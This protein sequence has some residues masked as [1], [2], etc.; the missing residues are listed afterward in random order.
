MASLK[1]IIISFVILGIV[2]YGIEY[3]FPAIRGQ[4]I[5]RKGFAVDVVYWLFTPLVT[6]AL[7]RA[8][9]IGGVALIALLL[10]HK[11]GPELAD[12]FGPVTQQPWWLIAMEMLVLGD[13]IG[14]WMHRAFHWGGLWKFHAVHHSSEQLDWL[15]SVRLHP[16]ND[17]LSR[18]AQV[19]VLMLLG[20][21]LT[22]LAAYVPFLTLYAI[23][24]H[25]NVGWD[26]G[27]LRHVI[28]SPRFHRWHHTSEAEGQNRNFAG[29]LPL[30]DLLFGTFHMPA[31]RQPQ[32]F[33]VAGMNVP[34]TF[35]GQ[36]LFPFR[37]GAEISQGAREAR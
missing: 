32:H 5:R 37:S 10:G 8:V 7:T 14:Y 29:L 25:A 6:K 21:P 13:F 17:V 23:L 30:W 34:T 15:S 4:P 36:L 9:T 2:F 20:F 1:G 19:I 28:A 16:V 27:P 31:G 3:L 12:G 18:L 24:L 35:I 33:G 11:L 26:Y 22:A